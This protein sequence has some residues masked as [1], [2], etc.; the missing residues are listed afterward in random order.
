M[1]R[2]DTFAASLG[3]EHG[4]QQV[5]F[6]ISLNDREHAALTTRE[7]ILNVGDLA[8]AAANRSTYVFAQWID[9]S[10][11]YAWLAEARKYSYAEIDAWAP[12]PATV[13]AATRQHDEVIRM[14]RAFGKFW[15]GMNVSPYAWRKFRERLQVA[16]GAPP[17]MVDGTDNPVHFRGIDVRGENPC[18][19]DSNVAARG[20]WRLAIAAAANQY[21]PDTHDGQW[22]ACQVLFGTRQAWREG[23]DNIGCPSGLGCPAPTGEQHRVWMQNDGS[24]R[25]G[26]AWAPAE[27]AAVTG[28]DRGINTFE[29]DGIPGGL[30]DRGAFRWDWQARV[31]VDCNITSPYGT[32][33]PDRV[34]ALAPMAWYWRLLREPVAGLRAVGGTTDL[35]LIDYLIATPAE[36]L[37]REIARDVVIRNTSMAQEHHVTLERL[38]GT[39]LEEYARRQEASARTARDIQL[40]VS[41]VSSTIGSLNPIAAL[42]G[43][44]VSLTSSIVAPLVTRDDTK[45]I[46]V[47]GRLMPAFEQFAMFGNL[48]IFENARRNMGYPDGSSAESWAEAHAAEHATWSAA[49]TDAIDPNASTVTT[50]T[51]LASAPTNTILRIENMPPAGVVAIDGTDVTARGRWEDDA[52]TVLVFVVSQGSHAVHV[53]PPDGSWAEDGSVTVTGAGATFDARPPTTTTVAVLGAPDASWTFALVDASSA[54]TPLV[55]TPPMAVGLLPGVYTLDA[56]AP[57]GGGFKTPIGLAAGPVTLVFGDARAQ[58]T[59]KPVARRVWPWVVLGVAALGGAAWATRARP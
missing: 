6:A 50:T 26:T 56:T 11:A 46:D 40:V 9:T 17:E 31:T 2:R 53:A 45:P 52:H 29:R 8:A 13:E 47:F 43:G 34:Y 12:E 37:L 22:D 25:G 20:T 27:I 51:D 48:S 39:A 14:W 38:P 3:E 4:L 55:G 44:A 32:T 42:I 28:A 21:G 24:I 57:D 18:G 10:L 35:S 59:A 36:A 5:L 30:L 41:S 1:T 54:R 15:R 19:R 7:A 49:I 23:Q 16:W 33:C 58:G